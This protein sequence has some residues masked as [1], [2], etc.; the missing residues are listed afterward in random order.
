MI[1]N[2]RLQDLNQPAYQSSLDWAR[3]QHLID[4]CSVTDSDFLPELL[5]IYSENTLELLENLYQS[6]RNQDSSLFRRTI[7]SLRSSSSNV[8]AIH[9]AALCQDLEN[10]SHSETLEW[11]MEHLHQI[12]DEYVRVEAAL[13]FA[14]QRLQISDL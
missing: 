8:G 13:Q 9:L 12:R 2:P 1:V 6:I 5:Q 4:S 14:C 7:H 10:Q 3:L 11:T